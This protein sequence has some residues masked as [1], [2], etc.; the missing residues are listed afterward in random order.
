MIDTNWLIGLHIPAALMPASVLWLL[1]ASFVIILMYA[2]SKISFKKFL[3][4]VSG[5][6]VFFGAMVMLFLLWGV[7]AGVSPGLGFHHL[8]ATL[9]TLMFGWPLAI[10]GLSIIMLASVLLQ[11]NELVSLGA[12]GVLSIIIP[13]SF[14][15]GILK[16][17]Q[18]FLPDNFFIY[19]F[20][21]AFFGAGI[22]V[23][24]SRLVSIIL[25]ALVDAYP[26]AK[27]IEESLL[28]TPLFMFPEMFVTGMLV[29]IFVVY[30]P[31]WVA[32]FDD[33]RYI[34]GK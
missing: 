11:H 6:H 10:I 16:L 17:S 27:L 2:I 5:Q 19:I 18:R 13:V 4:D 7:K 8:G 34:V 33:E 15:F 29:S 9:F 28:Y 25:L 21:V 23:A 30:R 31:A 12:N 1:N 24:A 32:T 3:E 26:L 20:V 14:S 22:A